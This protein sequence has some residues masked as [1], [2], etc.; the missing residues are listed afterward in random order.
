MKVSSYHEEEYLAKSSYHEEGEEYL[1]GSTYIREGEEEYLKE[2]E[3]DIDIINKMCAYLNKKRISSALESPSTFYRPTSGED[4]DRLHCVHLMLKYAW[5]YNFAAPIKGLLC[6]DAGAKVLDVGCGLGIWTLE[7]ASEF[8]LA[9][10]YGIDSVSYFPE[11]VSP[12]NVE[13]LEAN[14]LHGLPYKDAEFDY[15]FARELIFAFQPSDFENIVMK[16]ILR[17][18]KP[19]GYIEFVESELEGHIST[20]ALLRWNNEG[21]KPWI[22]SLNIDTTINCRLQEIF[23]NTNQLKNI[24]EQRIK[25]PFGRSNDFVGEFA[26]ET[27]MQYIKSMAE[28]LIPFMKLTHEEYYNLTKEIDK[29]FRDE[30]SASYFWNRRIT[31]MK[32]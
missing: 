13:F 2:T 8:P 27:T 25:I 12:K 7:M 30:K 23:T 1:E 9:K 11:S 16:E 28:L 18:V 26:A 29:E 21:M 17:V 32:I 5:K 6:S 10:F 14:I 19:G 22:N 31:A 3:T 4:E 24:S 20:K 15:V